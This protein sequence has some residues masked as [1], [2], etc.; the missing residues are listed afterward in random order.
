M[1]IQTSAPGK[2]M[3]LG[4]HAV[5]RHGKAIVVAIDKRVHVRLSVDAQN[6]PNNDD[7]MLYEIKKGKVLEGNSI[8]QS[9]IDF[10]DPPEDFKLEIKSELKGV[11]GLGSSSALI[12]ALM[13]AFHKWLD[14]IDNDQLFL[15]CLK[16]VHQVQGGMGSGVDILA[17]IH[18]GILYCEKENSGT[19][20]LTKKTIHQLSTFSF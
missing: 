4:E 17:A 3:L 1:I 14:P 10:F 16:I 8:I 20:Y 9:V 5:L 15:N 19:S 18:G 12:V 2:A 6:L 11:K 13:A 7:W